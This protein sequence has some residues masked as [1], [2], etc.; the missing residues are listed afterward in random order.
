MGM[1]MESE[2]VGSVP[3][4]ISNDLR[5]IPQKYVFTDILRDRQTLAYL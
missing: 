4:T 3:G 5:Q 1:G 2:G